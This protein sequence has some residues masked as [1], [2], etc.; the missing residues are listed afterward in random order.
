MSVAREAKELRSQFITRGKNRHECRHCGKLLEFGD[1][2]ANF[3]RHVF[4][5]RKAMESFGSKEGKKKAYLPT[6]RPEQKTI[7]ETLVD[8]KDKKHCFVDSW[9]LA[10]VH[11]SVAES[12]FRS[13]LFKDAVRNTANVGDHVI[14]RKDWKASSARWRKKIEEE[15][16]ANVK[17]QPVCL[18]LDGWRVPV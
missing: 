14:S 18:I 13:Q 6:S 7:V 15:I 12:F 1:R 11:S 3:R 5:C 9:Y 2:V 10:C 8:A 4:S 16:K 17:G